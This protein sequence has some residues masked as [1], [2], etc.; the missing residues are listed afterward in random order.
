VRWSRYSQVND[1]R[2][3]N[4]RNTALQMRTRGEAQIKSGSMLHEL[5]TMGGKGSGGQ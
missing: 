5:G 3:A 2:S 1:G 4:D